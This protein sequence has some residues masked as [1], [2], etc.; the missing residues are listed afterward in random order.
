MLH[1]RATNNKLEA[2]KID[3]SEIN[4][5]REFELGHAVSQTG[6]A[7]SSPVS[8][9]RDTSAGGGGGGGGRQ[10]GLYTL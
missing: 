8:L 5:S 9:L 1:V 6:L 10:H 3:N 4:P 2:Y 7:D